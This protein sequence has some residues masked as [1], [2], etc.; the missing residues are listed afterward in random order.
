MFSL[1]LSLSLSH[2]SLISLFLS[3]S[4]SVS[5]SLS[6]SLS[7]SL[8][9]SLSL[10]LSIS[11]CLHETEVVVDAE[12]GGVGELLGRD[13]FGLKVENLALQLGLV[14]QRLY[15]ET[16]TI[17]DI[18]KTVMYKATRY[19]LSTIVYTPPGKYTTERHRPTVQW[20]LYKCQSSHKLPT[21]PVSL[22]IE[23]ASQN[24]FRW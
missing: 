16:K 20:G 3:L 18:R 21:Q 4:L 15:V 14:H 23:L 2:S 12:N 9:L 11:L 13:G 7:Q 1:S 8:S 17:L 10:S 22:W 5:L 6:L 24:G 19:K